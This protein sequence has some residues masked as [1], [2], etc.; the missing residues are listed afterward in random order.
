MKNDPKVL[1]AVKKKVTELLKDRAGMEPPMK[2]WLL[3]ARTLDDFR[4]ELLHCI[5]TLKPEVYHPKPCTN[6]NCADSQCGDWDAYFVPNKHAA[7][8]L[9]KLRQ[10]KVLLQK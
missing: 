4:R 9:S 3:A 8:S 6:P 5:E 7:K 1:N 2:G 10:I